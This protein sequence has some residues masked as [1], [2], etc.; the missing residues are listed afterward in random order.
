MGH[1][2]VAFDRLVR[3]KLV[4][5]RSWDYQSGAATTSTALRMP[6]KKVEYTAREVQRVG[7]Q[8]FTRQKMTFVGKVREPVQTPQVSFSLATRSYL[9]R[10][11]FRY[12]R[13]LGF[14]DIARYGQ[15][16]RG[17]LAL[18]E[19]EHLAAPEQLL[20]AWG[21]VH[22]LYWSSDVL[23]RRAR[24][25]V[26][27]A[28][29]SLAELAPAPMFPD[30][31]RGCFAEVLLLA[32]DRALAAGPRLRAR[33]DRARLRGRAPRRKLPIVDVIALIR[34]P[35]P[36]LAALG[37]KLLGA[38]AGL[39]NLPVG[40]WLEL[41]RL[42]DPIAIA[43]VC[44]LALA[45]LRPDRVSL[46]QAVDL[47]C[48]RPTPVAE[49]G[50]RWAK[51][52][53]SGTPDALAE[54]SRLTRAENPKVRADAVRF[55]VEV[56]EGLPP[57]IRDPRTGPRPLRRRRQARSRRGHRR[58]RAVSALPGRHRALGGAR[59]G[60]PRDPD[61]ARVPGAAT[62]DVRQKVLLADE[63]RRL[64]ASTLLAVFRGSRE[65]RLALT[66]IA[67]RVVQGRRPTRP[68]SS[69]SFAFSA[70]ERPQRASAA[71]PSPPSRAAAF[72]S[73]E[74]SAASFSAPPIPELRP[75]RAGDRL[76][77]LDLR[78]LG[79]SGLE[80]AG[81]GLALHFSPNLARPP[82]FFDA[83]VK[84]PLRFREAISS[85]HDVVI[86]DLR[87]GDKDRTA[88]RA[89]K[90]EEQKREAELRARIAKEAA[91]AELA[92]QAK[93]PVPPN[94]DADFRKMHALYWRARHR[95]ASELWRDD[96]ELFR[97]LVPCDPVVTVAPD[98]VFFE[99]FS[100]DQVELR[101]PQRRPRRVRGRGRRGARHDQ[102]RLL[103][104]ALRP[105]SRAPLVS[106]DA[107]PRRPRGLLGRHPRRGRSARG[108]DRSPR[109]VAPRLRPALGGD[110]PPLAQ[111]R[112]LGRR[113]LFNSRRP[114]ATPRRAGRPRA[115][116]STS[117]PARRPRSSSSRGACASR[118]A[119]PRTRASR[120]RRA[121]RLR[122]SRARTAPAPARAR[123]HTDVVK[124]WGR[125]RLFALARLLPLVSKIEVRLLGSG[126]PSVWIAHA[127]DMRLVL[128]LSGWTSNDWA[129]GANLDLIAGDLRD[130]PAIT[131]K[132]RG[133]ARARQIGHDRRARARERRQARGPARRP[134]RPRQ[135]GPNRLR[136]RV[137]AL[138]MA[139]D[140]AGPARRRRP[141]TRAEGGVRG[142]ASR[143]RG[144]SSASSEQ[145]IPR[146]RAR[147]AHVV[148]KVRSAPRARRSSPTARSRAPSAP[149]L[150]FTNSG[151]AAARAA[152]SSRSGSRSSR[153]SRHE[154]AR[155]LEST[156]D[157]ASRAGRARGEGGRL[158]ARQGRR[159]IA[160]GARDG[161]AA[162]RA[163]AA[164]RGVGSRCAED[165]RLQVVG[166]RARARAAR[167]RAPR[168]RARQAAAREPRHRIAQG[169]D[170]R[171]RQGR[172]PARREPLGD[173]EPR[174]DDPSPQ[175]KGGALIAIRPF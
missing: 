12:F 116:C 156:A 75:R 9:K 54:L 163:G 92:K 26:V 154:R 159:R 43:T 127:G 89:Y 34:S 30:A 141:R 31:W 2:L 72:R 52:K 32:R 85:L 58:P 81:D 157:V 152:T 149:A 112:A 125:R 40:D 90:A 122:P 100:K 138:S 33:P 8:P 71:P 48:A 36:E 145:T 67:E 17:A 132:A 95:W 1:F 137:G 121:R 105:L 97:H 57:Q 22:A 10:R 56:L 164:R 103:D 118:A 59:R 62:L 23:D 114:G 45:K 70:P 50:L 39:D 117:R 102:R 69:R 84:D 136:L 108:E 113:P 88:W 5:L 111:D 91:T 123:V 3:R 19:D 165:P 65:K 162:R 107:A 53:P 49:L 135:A 150:I 93:R 120:R 18:Y 25:V 44:E 166:G 64:W 168:Q 174:V 104:G 55:Y 73:P 13:K 15:A 167:R 169:L 142:Q 146:R 24:G 16:I 7:D 78:Y 46:A 160:R 170:R 76:M 130:D 14:T 96:P 124:V 147:G 140:P 63:R 41:L 173:V 11:A 61:R 161:R 79:H 94:L 175:A 110:G 21:L 143:A 128:A 151:C 37:S 101:V 29:R 47:A 77:R 6:R 144:R 83:E 66:Q 60:T 153:A 35:E 98:V 109:D 68:R 126:L 133:D 171:D 4:T 86:S 148:A 82:T 27:A 129:G 28:G 119:A 115:S 139:A 74:S 172:D 158:Y 51:E 106:T 134:P 80:R 87:R 131:A 38:V 155:A 20:D 99:C 42:E